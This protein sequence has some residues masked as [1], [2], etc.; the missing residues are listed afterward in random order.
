MSVRLGIVGGGFSGV[1]AAIHLLRQTDAELVLFERRSTVGHGIAYGTTAIEHRLNVP[2]ARMS[3]DPE[4]PNDFVDFLR[5]TYAHDDPS[6]MVPRAWYGAYLQHRFLSAQT[7]FPSRLQ[8][9]PVEVTEITRRGELWKIDTADGMECVDGVLVA[10]GHGPVNVPTALRQVQASIHR[11]PWT[12]AA[13]SDASVLIV[14]TGLTA[15]DMLLSLRARGHRGR[16]VVTSRHGRFPRPHS[17]PRGPA[18]CVWRDPTSLV[19]AI[20]QVRQQLREANAQNLPWAAVI[21]SLRPHTARW[22]ATLS[23]DDRRSFLAHVRPLWEIH[24]HRAPPDSLAILEAWQQQGGWSLI[25]GPMTHAASVADEIQ[26]TWSHHRDRFQHVLLCTGNSGNPLHQPIL[27]ALVENGTLRMD[28]LELGVQADPHGLA[29]P[30]GLW[31]IGGL[32]RGDLW[33]STAVPELSRQAAALPAAVAA[34]KAQ[35][36]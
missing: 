19:D 23:V 31:V 35:R 10:T 27:A 29:H 4:S 5:E 15:V 28:P 22:W 13:P 26:V 1:A 32:R 2:A 8:Y 16:L 12:F 21:D 30:D 3:V 14:G 33:E 17:L 11:D 25:A 20:G 24:R 7:Q 9:R 18:P 34:W 36:P 6:A